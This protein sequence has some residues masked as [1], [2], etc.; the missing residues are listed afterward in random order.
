MIAQDLF[1]RTVVEHRGDVDR[2]GVTGGRVGADKRRAC[3]ALEALWKAW[4]YPSDLSL[5]EGDAEGY[6]RITGTWADIRGFSHSKFS[7]DKDLDGDDD[8]APKRRNQRMLD[9]GKPERLIIFPGGPGTRHMYSICHAA[10]VRCF[11]VAFTDIGGIEI[12]EWPATPRKI[13]RVIP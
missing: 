6:D 13:S 11:E 8:Q 4:G 9:I 5:I 2:P 1:K 7:I 3:A 10:G 12:H